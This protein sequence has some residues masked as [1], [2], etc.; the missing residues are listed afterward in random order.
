MLEVAIA[1]FERVLESEGI[2]QPSAI[3]VQLSA[4][5]LLQPPEVS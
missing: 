2:S 5:P 1:A 3:S 4:K